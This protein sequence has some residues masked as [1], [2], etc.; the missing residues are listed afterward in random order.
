MVLQ[1]LDSSLTAQKLR[2]LKQGLQLGAARAQLINTNPRQHAGNNRTG[3]HWIV[4][5]AALFFQSNCKDSAGLWKNFILPELSIKHFSF[6]MELLEL[7]ITEL[8]CFVQHE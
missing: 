6:I 4:S 1:K 7:A 3:V 2:D 5:R 8:D